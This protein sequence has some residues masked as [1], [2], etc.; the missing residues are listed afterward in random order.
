[1]VLRKTYCHIKSNEF[2]VYKKKELNGE[3]SCVLVR[4]NF[5]YL[6]KWFSI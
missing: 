2:L 6:Y 3:I 1:M 5:P 4:K